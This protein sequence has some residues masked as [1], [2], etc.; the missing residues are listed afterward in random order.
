MKRRRARLVKAGALMIA[1]TISIAGAGGVRLPALA[2]TLACGDA[3]QPVA[4]ANLGAAFSSYRGTAATGP[5]D[6]W[7]VG[8]YSGSLRESHALI[9]HWDGVRWIQMPSPVGS[10]SSRLNAAAALNP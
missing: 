3:W 1:V 5:N 2:S 10:H 6:A 4:G 7:I 9:E 8:E